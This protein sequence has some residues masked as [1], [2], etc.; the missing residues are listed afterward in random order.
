M[1]LNRALRAAVAVAA[2]TYVLAFLGIAVWRMRY[3][4]ELNWLEGAGLD[5]VRRILSGLPIYATPTLDFI[6]FPYTPLYFYTSALVARVIGV[7][8][9]AMR[10]VSFAAAIA[11][12]ALIF[13]IVRRETNRSYPAWIACGLTAAT[14]GSSGGWF[15]IARPDSLLVATLLGGIFAV[16]RGTR[17]ALVA[18]GVCLAFSCLTKQTAVMVT[19]PLMAWS[20]MKDRR[21]SL[22]LITP[23]V[24]VLAAAT[25]YFQRTTDGW[26][27]Y[28][29]VELQATR[30]ALVQARLL[31]FWTGDV[32]KVLAVAVALST[33]YLST[34]ARMR[35]LTRTQGLCVAAVTM[36]FAAWASR[37]RAGNGLNVLM[38]AH[39]GIAILSG[40]AIGDLTAGS[41]IVD[42]L[43]D[44]KLDGFVSALCLVQFFWLA[45]N[46]FAYIPTRNDEIAGREI[47][48][49]LAAIDGEVFVPCHGYLAVMAG[50][51]SYAHIQEIADVEAPRADS[52]KAAAIKEALR[53]D[54]ERRR[55]SAVVP[56]ASNMNV[57]EAAGLSTFYVK[58]DVLF[59]PG[60]SRFRTLAG[61]APRRP[62]AIYV[63][64]EGAAHAVVQ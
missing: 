61:S 37:L 54:F 46:P 41:V 43:A 9:F 56:C 30:G 29:V 24:V 32:F 7:D 6:A 14:Y 49:R 62:E 26:F 18:G 53:A 23:I 1:S 36:I 45:F 15:A 35:S 51:R 60:D 64:R 57:L 8:F 34:N 44:Q 59:G 4:F 47:V 42:E 39:A 19:I 3:P 13:A 40:L 5:H 17:R 31:T 10:L 33:W 48:R 52:T 22:F 63:P 2:G 58:H 27:W 55:F 20:I 50:K 28:Y 38:P 12:L 25:L 21:Q 11:M 16:Q